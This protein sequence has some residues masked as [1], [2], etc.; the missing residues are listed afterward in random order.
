MLN[1]LQQWNTFV[2]NNSLHCEITAICLLTL[3]QKDV[4]N[5]YFKWI[6]GKNVNKG[7]FYDLKKVS[8]KLKS[9]GFIYTLKRKRGNKQLLKIQMR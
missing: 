7:S 5:F 9:E 6:K 4:M 8:R 1:V 2:N 3:H